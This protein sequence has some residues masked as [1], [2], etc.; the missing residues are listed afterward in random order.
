[1]SFLNLTLFMRL[2][3][4]C[5]ALIFIITAVAQIL[6]KIFIKDIQEDFEETRSSKPPLK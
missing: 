3:V 6:G 2:F 1:M 5:V 4:E